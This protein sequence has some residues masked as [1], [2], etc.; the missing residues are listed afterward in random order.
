MKHKIIEKRVNPVMWN[1]PIPVEPDEIPVLEKEDYED[2]L[3]K[4]WNM[5][6]AAGYDTIIIYGDREHFS[7]VEYFTGYDPRWEETLFILPR[8]GRACI[9]VGNECIG[10]VKKV[11]ID[12]DVILY[13]TFSLMGQPNDDSPFLRDILSQRIKRENGKI[14]IIGFKYYEPSKHTIEG[15]ITDVPSYMIKTIC[16]V[17]PEENLENATLLMADCRY[18]LKHQVSAKEIVIFEAAGTRIS[19]GILHCLQNLKPGMTE[20]EASE[21]CGFD[22]SPA[23]MHPNINF[24]EE[25]VALGLNSP[26]EQERLKYGMPIGAGYGLRGSLVHKCG[27]YLRDK[28]DLPAEKSG[29]IEEFLMP[30]FENVVS[31]YEMLKPG[32][33]GREVYDMVDCELGLKA[34]GCTLNPG[35]LTHTDEWTNSPFY[36]GSQV[37]LKSGMAFQCDYTVTRQE[38]FMSAHVEDG[39]VIA[40]KELREG[41]K[42][43]SPGCWKRIMQRRDFIVKELHI[44]LPEEILPLSDLSCVCFPY[45]ADTGVV[46]A[47]E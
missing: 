5:P 17:V 26:T 44:N 22:G 34:F 36:Q 38:P 31:W 40:D 33:S 47:C 2:R 42:R 37:I 12:V 1:D 8:G 24:G 13:Q 29:Y 25:N 27:M 9:L 30:Y 16:Q 19:R 15:F 28:G 23:N 10:Y 41:V 39:L 18:G 35:H 21:N 45:M 32:V 46:L 14:G 6:Q 3:R 11:K 7:N 20:R 43:L 4:L